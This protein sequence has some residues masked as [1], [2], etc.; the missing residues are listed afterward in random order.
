[1]VLCT[2]VVKSSTYPWWDW[3]K[4]NL[5]ARYVVLSCGLICPCLNAPQFWNFCFYFAVIHEKVVFCCQNC[6]D[7]LWE[8]MVLFDFN[9]KCGDCRLKHYNQTFLQHQTLD[10]ITIKMGN[11]EK[12]YFV[13]KIVLTYCEKKL[14]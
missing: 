1:M 3:H 6:S 8:K 10:L 7:L 2:S 9:F 13:T 4:T 14:L 11:N 5:T 12:C